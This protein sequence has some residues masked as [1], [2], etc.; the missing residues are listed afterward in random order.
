[1]QTANAGETL[2]KYWLSHNLHLNPGVSLAI[3]REFESRF[4]VLMPSDLLSYFARVNG[5]PSNETDEDLVRFW[6]LED[7]K[8]IA[9]GSPGYSNP[10]YLPGAKSFFLFADY[11]IWSHHY[12][13][14]LSAK[15]EEP[16][17]V[18]I[19]GYDKPTLVGESFT[20]F[21]DSYING[22]HLDILRSPSPV[23]DLRRE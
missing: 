20:Q 17:L 21:V 1:M 13:I 5:M 11:F 6:P 3:V 2:R 18:Y 10:A 4:G 16:N 15:T 8:T 22:K 23:R 14:R 12:A 19:I 9:A 7:V